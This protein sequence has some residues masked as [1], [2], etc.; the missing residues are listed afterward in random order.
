MI[1]DNKKCGV[2]V[3][4][5]ASIGGRIT[6]SDRSEYIAKYQDT[7]MGLLIMETFLEKILFCR[8]SISCSCN[9]SCIS[10]MVVVVKVVVV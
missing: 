8:S 6:V 5:G 10:I 4:H 2:G 9:C 7:S 3:A 1:A